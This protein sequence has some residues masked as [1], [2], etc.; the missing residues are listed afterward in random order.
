MKK[1]LFPS[2]RLTGVL[3]LLCA[4]IYPLLMLG[5]AQLSPN[6]G[7][8]KL[9]IDKNGNA[10]FE[11]IGQKF[12]KD[13]YFHSRPSA[14]DYNAASSGGSNRGPDDPEYLSVVQ[15]RVADF[16]ARNPHAP[17]SVSEFKAKGRKAFTSGITKANSRKA[18]T[19]VSPVVEVPV[20]MVTASGSGLDPHISVE[21][22]MAQA[23]RVAAAKRLDLETVHDLVNQY[24]EKNPF[25]PE[26]VNVLKINIALDNLF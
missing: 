24:T 26:K 19:S 5:V 22:A 6:H 8:G 3:L 4:V 14:V 12:D 25:G 17:V 16:R 11:N 20:D 13:I 10:Y 18:P 1:Y 15:T 9:I 21:S 2:L 23:A 7:K